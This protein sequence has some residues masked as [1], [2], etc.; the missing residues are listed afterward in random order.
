MEEYVID[1]IPGGELVPLDLVADYTG[2]TIE[3]VR[4][5]YKIVEIPDEELEK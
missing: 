2:L 4:D 5:C 3:Q 1:F